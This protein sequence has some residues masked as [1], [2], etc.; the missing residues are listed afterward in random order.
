VPVDLFGLHGLVEA[1]EEPE[2]GGGA[3]VDAQSWTPWPGQVAGRP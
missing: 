2:L 3:V 1:L